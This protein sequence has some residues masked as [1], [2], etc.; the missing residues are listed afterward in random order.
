MQTARLPLLAALLAAGAL[1]ATPAPPRTNQQGDDF[2]PPASRDAWLSRRSGLREQ[3][4]IATGL[5]PMLPRTPLNPRI[6]G[7]ID[8]GDYTVEKVVL[9]TLPGYFLS[10]NLYRPARASG[11]APAILNPHGHWTNGR[12]E[13]DLQARCIGQARMGAV[14]FMYDMVGYSDSKPFGHSFFNDRLHLLGL[15]LVGLQLWNSI[16]ALDW[17]ESLPG[18]DRERIACTGESGGGTQ[19]FLLCAVD[20][21]IAVSAPVCMVSHHFQGGCTCENAPS[22]RVG[23]DN[24]ELAAMFAPKPQI[25]V[26]ATGDWTSQILERGVPE[27]REVYQLFGQPGSFQAVVHKA[28]HNYNRQS[29]E[30]V[31]TFLRRHLWPD[32]S[33]APASEAANRLDG[34]NDAPPERL[35][36]ISRRR[37]PI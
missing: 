36:D 21:R 18:V 10:G 17:L 28:D 14:A 27:I 5:S 20:D 31:Y 8:A 25:L 13:S 19:T 7:R 9:E 11:R 12:M 33:P 32:A 35:S 22:L 37:P 2:R 34:L 26:G 15:N 30:S 1:A 23:T 29:R 4:L 6:Y 16:R 3:V 24:V